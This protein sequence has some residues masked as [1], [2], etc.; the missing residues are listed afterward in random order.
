MLNYLCWNIPSALAPENVTL[1]VEQ[2]HGQCVQIVILNKSSWQKSKSSRSILK[3]QKY[4]LQTE[5]NKYKYRQIK[6]ADINC[7][8]V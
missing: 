5:K 8:V 1:F 2:W 6:Y 4:I 3:C 7:L